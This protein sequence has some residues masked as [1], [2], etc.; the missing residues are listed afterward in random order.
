MKHAIWLLAAAMPLAAQPKLL[1]NAQ[2]QT[3]SAAAG[4]E[5][6]FK[7]LLSAQPQPA[8]IAYSVPSVRTNNLGCDYVR[9][10]FTQPGVVHLE[11]PDHAVI[12]FRVQENVVNRI[13]TL[14]P[15]CEIDAG[16]VP[17]HWL[18]DVQPAQSIALLVSLMSQRDRIGDNPISAIAQHA[19]P[20][21]DQALEGFLATNQPESMRLRAVSALGSARGRHGFEVLKRLISSDPDERVRERAISGLSSS[22]EPDAVAL[23]ISIAK[24][25]QNSRMRQQ[26]VSALARKPGPEVVSTISKVIESDPDVQVKRHAVS[27]L[28]QLP[29]GTGIPILIQMVKTTQNADVRKQAMNTLQNSRDPRAIA[30]FEDVLKK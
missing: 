22:K 12:L 8:W 19:D 13:R 10:G 3:H 2:V 11:S 28:N 6:Q 5:S 9:D 16:G 20:A 30:F 17:L 26:A 24:T 25:D 27:S 21:A 1:I 4:L 14:S 23:L 15:D 7:A 18:T 29:D